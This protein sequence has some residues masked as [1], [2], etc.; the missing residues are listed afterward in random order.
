MV[1]PLPADQ[2]VHVSMSPTFVVAILEIF[3][4]KLLQNIIIIIIIIII[5][6]AAY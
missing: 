2:K 5:K 1:A 4:F 3:S 6:Y